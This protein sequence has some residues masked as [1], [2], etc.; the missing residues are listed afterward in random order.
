MDLP[1]QMIL[2]AQV[3]EAG[4]FSGAAKALGLSPSSVSRQISH[5]EDR[6]GVR[7]L[8]RLQFGVSLTAEGL[9]IQETCQAMA[10]KVAE[11][12]E[13]LAGMNGLPRGTLRVVA[14]VA[15]G[16]A[17]LLPIL[18]R[19][20]EDH[21]EVR[22]S[23]ELTD[24]PVNPA[25]DDVDVAIRFSE[26]VEDANAIQRKLAPNRRVLCAAPNYV[27]RRGAP[28]RPKDLLG[29]N[30]LRLSTNAQWNDWDFGAD[31]G[32]VL[33]VGGNFEANSADAIYHA[34]LAGVGI[35]RLSTYLIEDD[36]VSGRL[37]RLLPGYVQDDSAIVAIYAE[38]R[39]LAPKIRAFLDYLVLQFSGQTKP[40]KKLSRSMAG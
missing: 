33:P 30:C 8:N 34:A 20:L 17:Q 38:R 25:L 5:L 18:P 19:F 29:H 31:A 16:K 37:L 10:A 2:F 36:L 12:E 14:T 13:L 9:A 21:P 24:R 26:Q 28:K 3:V 32:G 4:S 35:A 7:L 11:A 23:L 27:A 40:E 15:F 1:S 6:V 22:I 39:N